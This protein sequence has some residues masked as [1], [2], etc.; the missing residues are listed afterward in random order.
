MKRLMLS[1]GLF[2]CGY[3]QA[4]GSSPTGTPDIVPHSDTALTGLF[5]GGGFKVL[6]A[7]MIGS[8]IICAD[9]TI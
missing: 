9:R 4:A 8:F 7:Q 3:Y 2:A 5:Y 6:E 1:L